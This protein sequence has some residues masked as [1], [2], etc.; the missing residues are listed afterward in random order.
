MANANQNTYNPPPY[1][2]ALPT[3]DQYS[4][5]NY[6]A[7]VPSYS[8]KPYPEI[9]QDCN[10]DYMVMDTNLAVKMSELLQV[11]REAIPIGWRLRIWDSTFWIQPGETIPLPAGEGWHRDHRQDAA[12][13]WYM[14]GD[15]IYN[16]EKIYGSNYRLI[17]RICG[18]NVDG[19]GNCDICRACRFLIDS[20]GLNSHT[21]PDSDLI[22]QMFEH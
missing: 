3:Y 1:S 6:C 12:L 8:L 9:I 15:Q 14:R 18:H 2:T 17:N 4:A 5:S 10:C 19:M 13:F 7:W 20:C 22:R 11:V 21:M 16:M